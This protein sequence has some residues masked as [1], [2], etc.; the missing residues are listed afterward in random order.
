MVKDP[1]TEGQV[2]R[3]GGTTAVVNGP[4]DD[5]LA[6][7]SINWPEVEDDVRRL[8]QRIFTAS[9]AGDLAKVRNLQ[10]LMLRSRANALVSVRRVTELNA[11]RKTAGVD[12]TVVVTAPGKAAMVDRVRRR[13]IAPTARPVKR[14]YI[15]K[16]NGKQRPLGIPVIVDRVRQ[17]QVV[18]ALEPEWEARF[19]PKSYGFRLGRGCHDAIEAIFH[20]ARGPNPSRRWV[21]DADLAAAFDR[22]DHERLLAHLGTFLA[23]EQIEGW[24]KAGVVEQGRFSPTEEG[25]PQ[26]G[27]VSP[28]LL[29][30]ALHGMEQAAGVRYQLNGTRVGETMA[31]SPVLIRYADDLVALCCTQ[32]QAEQVK[33]RL[34]EWLAPRGLVFNEDKTRIVNLDE[35]L[36]F[37]GFTVRRMSGKLL[38]KP[39][40]AALRRHRRRL[41][42]EMRSLRGA[43]V[44]TVLRR[45]VPIVRGWANY[46]RTV[47][48]SEMFS[49]LDR[50][51]WRLTY[52]W[53]KQSHPKKSKRWVVNRYFG[54]FNK[55]R[56]DRWV[57]GDRD[58]GA[59]LA[60]HAWTRIVRH[61][62]VKAASS[63]DDPA[64]AEYW[65]SR[66]R[67][68]APPPLDNLSLRL[69]QSQLGACPVCG[70]LLL[71]ADHPPQT[72]H[73]WEQWVRTT[74]RALAKRH[75]AHQE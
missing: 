19:E 49:A 59:Y 32:A 58:S 41:R 13:S 60:K 46:Y 39:S 25:T 2:G 12:G 72:P 51:L 52:K 21:L 40:K 44:A 28:L 73:E 8:R 23:R 42:H 48:S 10:K 16:A 11:G 14:V 47:V 7:G 70:E 61:Q 29:N 38:I 6:W 4:E 9:Q 43:N 36:D 45:L 62:M 71:Y 74:G 17:A 67:R 65:A 3:H 35:G 53:A 1:G 27:V 18:N 33:A 69:L 56:Q 57:F 15:P 22:I 55:S 34:A 66:R 75:I 20:V 5:N 64:L 31:G 54:R 37:L 63:P 30:V 24:L 26:G 50:Y 68:A